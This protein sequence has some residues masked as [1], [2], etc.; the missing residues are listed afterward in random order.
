MSALLL[1]GKRPLTLLV[2]LLLVVVG[3]VV[4]VLMRL[5]SLINNRLNFVLVTVKLLRSHTPDIL[6]LLIVL[7]FLLSLLSDLLYSVLELLVQNCAVQLNF[8]EFCLLHRTLLILHWRLDHSCWNLDIKDFL[9]LM[10]I[11]LL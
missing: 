1:L 8:V 11:Q 5:P 10:H 6:S 4:A 2:Y 7:M 3:L 9:L